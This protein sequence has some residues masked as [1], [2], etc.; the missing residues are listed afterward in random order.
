RLLLHDRLSQAI[1]LGRRHRRQLALLFVDV[2]RFKHVNDLLGHEA[3]DQLLRSVAAQLTMCVRSS[4]T[5]S[6]HG[7]DEFVVVL[8]EM[9][10]ARDAIVTGKKISGAVAGAAS[11]ADHEVHVT[12][13]IGISVYPTDGDSAETLLKHA[14]I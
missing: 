11:V 6:R 9:E 4:D 10:H 1:E 5:I 14:E 3:G 12:A 2:D 7:G 13:S 8:S